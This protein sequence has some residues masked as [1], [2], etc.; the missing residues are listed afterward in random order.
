[1]PGGPGEDLPAVFLIREIG[2]HLL[3]VRQPLLRQ[4]AGQ[5]GHGEDEAG[6]AQRG[7]GEVRPGKLIRSGH[8]E[9]QP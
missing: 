8:S 7:R 2:R 4:P 5:R 3:N 1:M 9:S 6:Q